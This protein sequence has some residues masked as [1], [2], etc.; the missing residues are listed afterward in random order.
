MKR[1]GTA[2]SADIRS[3]GRHEE[4]VEELSDRAAK[5]VHQAVDEVAETIRS[6][7]EA[8]VDNTKHVKELAE[9]KLTTHPYVSVGA[10]FAAGML[11]C[12]I[13]RWTA[14]RK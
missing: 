13:L 3:N 9:E 10:A 4:V 11:T 1:N 5:L 12:A 6:G 14:N 8:I 2:R 7:K